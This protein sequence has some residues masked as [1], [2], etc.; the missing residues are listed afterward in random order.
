MIKITLHSLTNAGPKQTTFANRALAIL[1]RVVNATDFSDSIRSNSYSVLWR[2]TRER[3]HVRTSPEELLELISGGTE[4]STQTD[5]EIE[6]S[7]NLRS[8]REGIMGSTAIGGPVINSAYWFI[9]DCIQANDAAYLAAHWMHE[10]LH[11]AGC[12]HVDQDDDDFSDGLYETGRLIRAMGRS[13]SSEKSKSATGSFI[14]DGTM[15]PAITEGEIIYE[16]G[17]SVFNSEDIMM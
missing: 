1:D 10:W 8:F 4:L 16:T 9:N 17:K 12:Y 3:N 13:I 14:M 6:F 5:F 15:G 7:I 11:T 2:R